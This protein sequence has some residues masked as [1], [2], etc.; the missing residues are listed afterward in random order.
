MT[1]GATGGF[2]SRGLSRV[3]LGRI[4][5]YLGFL[6]A[7]VLRFDGAVETGSALRGLVD[8]SDV[9]DEPVSGGA[10][11]TLERVSSV[12]L[13]LASGTVTARSRHNVNIADHDNQKRTN[14][15]KYLGVST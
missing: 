1:P 3:I 12:E 4:G 14:K 10:D 11:V 6:R 7:G 5:G 2:H 13:A 8:A 15:Q 9:V